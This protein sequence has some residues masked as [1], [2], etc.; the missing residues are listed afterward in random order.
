MTK[1]FEAVV[2]AA[3]RDAVYVRES[4]RFYRSSDA[5]RWIHAYAKPT[6]GAVVIELTA[7]GARR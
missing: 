7:A 1:R 5:W 3:R 4:R 2:Y 6:T